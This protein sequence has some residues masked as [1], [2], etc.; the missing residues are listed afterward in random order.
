MHTKEFD[1]TLPEQLIAQVPLTER[2][3]SK[4]LVVN[5]SKQTISHHQF[6]DI[7]SYLKPND[8][9]VLNDTKVIKARLFAKRKTGAKIEIFLLSPITKNQWKVLLK[10]TKRIKNNEELEIAPG[11]TCQIIQKYYDQDQHL[12]SFNTT[13]SIYDELE[14]HGLIPLPP[15]IHNSS[16]CQINEIQKEYQTVF[17]NSPGA[18]AAPTAGL[19]FT[20]TLLKKIQEQ[21]VNMEFVTLHVGY[22]TFKPVTAKNILEH[23]M[24]EEAFYI[25][26]ETA[27]NLNKAI[28]QKQRIISVGTTVTRTLESAFINNVFQPGAGSSNLF[29]YPGYKFKTISG[30]ITN[31]HLPKSTLLMLVSAFAGHDLT[32]EAYKQA[33]NNNYRFYSFGDSMLV[34]P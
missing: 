4:L 28:K 29:I 16:S 26:K 32:K 30:L 22:G 3:R 24:H 10:P 27:T 15:Y 31:F 6:K 19:H 5:K 18:V 14:L 21:G 20:P 13:S 2:D 33:I 34:L 23:K 1:Y 12:V 9:L 11:F 17:A 8:T 7:L 25:S